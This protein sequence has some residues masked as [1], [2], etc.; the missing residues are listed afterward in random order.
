MR[1]LEQFFQRAIFIEE[2]HSRLHT[3]SRNARDIIHAITGQRLHINHAV[4][5]HAEFLF[6]FLDADIF[7]FHRVAHDDILCHQLHEVLI[8]ADDGAARAGFVRNPRIGRDEIIRFKA[9]H[10]NRSR[11]K[12]HRRFAGQRELRDQLFGR[13]AAIGLIQVINLISE[14]VS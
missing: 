13:L 14:R 10:F 11:A 9:F 1:P 6:D 5:F 12:C 2:Q 7:V 4:R 8:R 3:N